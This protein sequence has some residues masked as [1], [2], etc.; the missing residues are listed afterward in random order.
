MRKAPEPADDVRMFLGISEVF[1][2]V[3]SAEQVDAAQL[4][5][6]VFRMH[7]WQIQELQKGRLDLSVGAAGKRAACDLER[8]S[9]S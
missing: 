4:V 3:G 1:R 6:Q 2:I 9:V 7:E 8:Q 5:G